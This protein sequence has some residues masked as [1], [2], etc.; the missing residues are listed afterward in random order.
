[1]CMLVCLCVCH[2]DM[3]VLRGQKRVLRPLELELQAAVGILVLWDS[4]EC[5]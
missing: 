2:E 5:S 3:G 4:S 1:M